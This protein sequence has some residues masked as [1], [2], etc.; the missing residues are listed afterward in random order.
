MDS[1]DNVMSPISKILRFI[2]RAV[3]CHAEQAFY[4]E[5]SLEAGSLSLGLFRIIL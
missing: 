2:E 1:H 3:E 5:A 4:E